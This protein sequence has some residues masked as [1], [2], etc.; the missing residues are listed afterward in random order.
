MPTRE[1]TVGAE[2]RA[3]QRRGVHRD[4]EPGR[5]VDAGLAGR[6]VGLGDERDHERPLGRRGR[7]A[8]RADVAARAV[9]VVVLRGRVARV[10]AGRAG[11]EVVVGR[12]GVGVQRVVRY[13]ADARRG[14]VV[15]GGVAPHAVVGQ[16]RWRAADGPVHA[17]ERVAGDDVVHHHRAVAGIVVQADAVGVN[18]VVDDGRAGAGRDAVVGVMVD[19][20]V[21]HERGAAVPERDAGVV[22]GDAAADDFGPGARSCRTRRRRRASRRRWPRRES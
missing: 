11:L 16:A 10:D 17:V 3:G 1:R 7:A 19:D 2:G 8:V 13:R 15:V 12:R 20:A 14:L 5:D 18:G 22:A 9:R 6:V 21:A 4:V